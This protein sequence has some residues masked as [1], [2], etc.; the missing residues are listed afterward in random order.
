MKMIIPKNI[1]S[2]TNYISQK[3]TTNVVFLDEDFNIYS[4]N[5]SFKDFKIFKKKIKIEI[6]EEFTF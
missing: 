3:N 1:I 2:C 6:K 4:W 5:L